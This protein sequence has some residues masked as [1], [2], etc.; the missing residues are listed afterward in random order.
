MTDSEKPLARIRLIGERFQNGHLPIDSLIEL[1]KYQ[2]AIRTLAIAEWKTNN[3]TSTLPRDFSSQIS[4]SIHELKSGSADIYIAFEQSQ[5]IQYQLE[6]KTNVDRLLNAAYSGMELPK[7]NPA[8]EDEVHEVLSELGETLIDGQEF[9]IFVH[10]PEK[11][12]VTVTVHTRKAAHDALMFGDF[13]AQ[14]DVAGEEKTLDKRSETLIGRITELDADKMQFRFESL[15]FGSLKAWYKTN[16][17]LL[18]DIKAVLDSAA[19]G[20][21]VRLDG[22]LQTRFGKPWRLVETQ[23]IQVFF[24]NG[25][26]W[27]KKLED[28]ATLASG[29]GDGTEQIITF[30]ALDASREILSTISIDAQTQPNVFPTPEGGVLIEWASPISVKSIEIG[31]NAEFSLFHSKIDDKPAT[32]TTTYSLHEACQFAAGIL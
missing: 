25:G 30:V 11:E 12:P 5:H 23:N 31:P 17:E 18:H 14:D 24:P 4:L 10:G 29:W 16:P 20:S 15:Q 26:I 28:F 22:T 27:S 7:I 2:S 6:A 8:A 3:P 21:V 9:Q 32:F 19:L 1:E 13:W